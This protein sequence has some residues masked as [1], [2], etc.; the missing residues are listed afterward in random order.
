MNIDCSVII[1]FYE[2]IKYATN[3]L[4]LLYFM[5]ATSDGNAIA[6]FLSSLSSPFSFEQAMK[7]A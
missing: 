2:L 3:G 7:V 5:S 1:I 6:V 4:I